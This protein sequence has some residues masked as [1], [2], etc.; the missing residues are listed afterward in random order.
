MKRWVLWAVLWLFA[1]VTLADPPEKVG[2]LKGRLKNVRSQKQKLRAELKETRVQT[3]IV[4]ED[5]ATLE[6]RIVRVSREVRET[7]ED[8]AASRKDQARLAAQLNAG[9][10]KKT[11]MLAAV[12][13]RLRVMYVQ[14]GGTFLSVL[15][16]TKDVGD[17]VTRASLMRDIARKDRE[18]FNDYS[19]VVLEIA[20]DKADEDRVVSKIADLQRF[21]MRKNAELTEV[22]ADKVIALR[23]LAAKQVSLQAELRAYE[24]DER[25]ISGEIAAY[26]RR[27]AAMPKNARR[28]PKRS[29][30]L[31]WP[32]AGRITSGFGMRFHPILRV[33]RLHAGVDFGAPTGAPIVASADGIVISSGM[34]R[35]YG[36]RVILDHGGGL[37]TTYAHCSRLYVRAGQFVRRG[38]TIGAVGATGLATG[39]H[40]HFEV[41]VNGVPVNPRG[42]L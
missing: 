16:G 34:G 41:R 28:L 13:N 20:R 21:M 19:K 3:R 33:T 40:L 17:L 12:R 14:S 25:A 36:N 26:Y 11:R 39:P 23:Q 42:Y 30:R 8:L 4:K 15:A 9:T 6:A 37:S 18:L 1:G 10:A 29:G 38:Q 27:L 22:K 2:T 35:G 7:N 32:V 31:L 5:V 24:A